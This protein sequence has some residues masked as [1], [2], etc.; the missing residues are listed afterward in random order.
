[1]RDFCVFVLFVRDSSLWVVLIKT[2]ESRSYWR[3]NLAT[4]P[5][6]CNFGSANMQAERHRRTHR[7]KRV[8]RMDMQKYIGETTEY[9]KKQAVEVNFGDTQGDEGETSA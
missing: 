9:D 6:S 4:A 7:I 2:D 5:K 3:K 1:M 8:E